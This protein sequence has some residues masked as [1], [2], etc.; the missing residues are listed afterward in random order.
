MYLLLKM[1]IIKSYKLKTAIIYPKMINTNEK[2]DSARG[3]FI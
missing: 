2:R 1:T 3:V